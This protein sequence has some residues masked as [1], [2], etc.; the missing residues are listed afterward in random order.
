MIMRHIERLPRARQRLLAVTLALVAG[1]LALVIVLTPVLE[2]HRHYD[3]AIAEAAHRLERLQAAV[4]RTPDLEAE[5]SARRAALSSAD[6]FLREGSDS[7]AAAQMQEA[8]RGMV[9]AAGGDTG[10]TQVLEPRDVD[11][12][13]RIG[14]RIRLEGDIETLREF[15]HAV[16]TSRPMLLVEDLQVQPDARRQRRGQA[17]D[18]PV[19]LSVQADIT[20]LLAP[21][22]LLQ[23]GAD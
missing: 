21:G 8:L 19:I 10:S 12:F 22:A 3:T 9:D 5:V 1:V 6:L 4:A 7:L 18:R 14:V 2:R 17:E 11:S 23:A 20:G 13:T 16:E 15:L